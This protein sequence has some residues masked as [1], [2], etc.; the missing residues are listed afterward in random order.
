MQI[1][2]NKIEQLRMYFDTA[3]R[4]CDRPVP[5]KP[6]IEMLNFIAERHNIHLQTGNSEEMFEIQRTRL[7]NKLIAM[8]VTITPSIP[9]VGAKRRRSP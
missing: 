1:E 3:T 5:T 6:Q 9:L 4:I 8:G 2:Q 7:Q